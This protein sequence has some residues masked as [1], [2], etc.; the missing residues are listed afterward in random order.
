MPLQ[1]KTTHSGSVNIRSSTSLSFGDEYL[2][3][4]EAGSSKNRHRRDIKLFKLE[5]NLSEFKKIIFWE[6]RTSPNVQNG[7]ENI[8]R[9]LLE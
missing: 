9:S 4:D 8:F 6:P 2:T 7:N 5:L 3:H 1:E